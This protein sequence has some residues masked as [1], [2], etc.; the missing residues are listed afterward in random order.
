MQQYNITELRLGR[1]I[2][3]NPMASNDWDRFQSDAIAA[4]EFFA[5]TIEA[6]EFWTEIH[7]GTGTWTDEKGRPVLEESAV[8]TLYWSGDLRP[9]S[10]EQLELDASIYANRYQQDA[11]AVVHGGR[12]TLVKAEEVTL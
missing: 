1:N 2:G 6:D 10:L 4:L 3:N 8:V 7:R 5:E 11:I 12:S 9:S